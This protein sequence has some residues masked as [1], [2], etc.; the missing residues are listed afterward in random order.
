MIGLSPRHVVAQLASASVTAAMISASVSEPYV[1]GSRVPR[2]PEVGAE[3]VEDLH[4]LA[5]IVLQH[6][7]ELVVG[8]IVDDHRPPDILAGGRSEHH[9]DTSCRAGTPRGSRRDPATTRRSPAR[10]TR[11]V[12]RCAR[13]GPVGAR[14]RASASRAANTMPTATASPCERPANASSRSSAWP[15]RVPVVEDQAAPVVAFVLGHGPGLR[16]DAAGHQPLERGRVAREDRA[17]GRAPACPG[18]R[19]RA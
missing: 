19:R 17:P 1:C 11:A 18:A 14:P 3:Q 10:T 2:A 5:P 9:L 12:G 6:P 7:S 13:R 8:H 15:E 16:R 4:T